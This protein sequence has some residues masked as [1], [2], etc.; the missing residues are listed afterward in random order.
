MEEKDAGANLEEES[1][2]EK[3]RCPACLWWAQPNKQ[4]CSQAVWVAAGRW[5]WGRV[6]ET[7]VL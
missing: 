6:T 1:A 4:R 7:S 5:G 2:E 3:A